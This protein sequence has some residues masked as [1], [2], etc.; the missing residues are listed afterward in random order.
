MTHRFAVA[1][2]ARPRTARQRG[3]SLVGLLLGAVVLVVGGVLI[4]RIVPA[5][6]EYQAVVKAVGKAAAEAA[7]VDEARIIFDRAAQ[8]DD[9]SSIKGRDL[10]ITRSPGEKP[11]VRFAYQREFH[12]AGPA[13]LTLKYSGQAGK[14]AP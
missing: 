6:L 5:T 7:T 2:A 12:L 1:A 3:F 13:F 11:L 4:A 9:I 14:A 10:E 8:V